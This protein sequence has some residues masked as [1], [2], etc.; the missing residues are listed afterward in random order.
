MGK[1][2]IRCQICGRKPTRKERTQHHLFPRIGNGARRE[3]VAVCV[4]CHRDIHRRF[5]NMELYNE[6][7]Q[8]MKLKEELEYRRI[9]EMIPFVDAR[10]AQSGRAL[11]L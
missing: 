9:A 7:N 3:K 4:Y 1:K 10:I 8:V 6:Y 2:E 11:A 5:R